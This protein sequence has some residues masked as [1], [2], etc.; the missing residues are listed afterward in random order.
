VK[1]LRVVAVALVVMSTMAAALQRPALFSRGSISVRGSHDDYLTI[2]PDGRLAV[3]TRLEDGYRGGTLYLADR[4]GERWTNVR[5]APFSGEFA[6]SRPAFAPS[7]RQI[8]FASDRPGRDREEGRSD[9]DIWHVEQIG[10]TWAEPRSVGAPVNTT[11][12]ESHPSITAD[13]SL[14][15]V[16][17]TDD[18][19]IYVARRDGPLWQEPERLPDTINTDRPDSHVFVDPSERVMLFG[20]LDQGRRRGQDHDDVYVSI[21]RDGVWSRARNIG[22]PVNT[23]AYEYSAKIYGSPP[24]LYFTRNGVWT[25][26]D[27][28]DVY[29]VPLSAVRALAE[30]LR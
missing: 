25:G 27:P 6:D 13:A 17:R 19:D 20:R 9:L 24:M 5:V 26:G 1:P 12:H 18:S 29:V 28:A 11:A 21:W 10:A 8:Y 15:F 23:S 14:Y 2:S 30:A 16:R 22:P 3:F 7:G 4:V